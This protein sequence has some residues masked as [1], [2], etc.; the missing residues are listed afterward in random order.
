MEEWEDV[1]KE[2]R[3]MAQYRTCPRCGAHLDHGERCDCTDRAAKEREATGVT[4]IERDHGPAIVGVDLAQRKDFTG[5]AY[6]SRA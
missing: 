3:R 6:I 4:P 1:G 2:T 5:K